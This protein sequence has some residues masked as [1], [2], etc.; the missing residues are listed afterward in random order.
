MYPFI[1]A[2]TNPTVAEILA[3]IKGMLDTESAGTGLW[4]ANHYDAANGWLEI[5][6]KGTPAGTLGSFRALLF[7]GSTPNAAA[8]AYLGTA[9]STTL[10][11]G[12]AQSASTTGPDADYD[13][14]APYNAGKRWTGGSY[15]TP[16]ANIAKSKTPYVSLIES[17]EIC[18]III[19]D[20]SYT[21][22]SIFGAAVEL[23]D[24][25][26]A[27]WVCFN[28][29]TTTGLATYSAWAQT[30]G[31]LGSVNTLST[32][33]YPCGLYHD[34]TN[35]KWVGRTWQGHSTANTYWKNPD[36]FFI[37]QSVTQ[38]IAESGSYMTEFLGVARQLKLGPLQIN[39][40][41]IRDS[42]GVMQGY[43]LCP[44]LGVEGGPLYFDN[45]K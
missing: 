36:G 30:L 14:A 7:G 23:P 31:Y 9:N 32:A 24:G 29:G 16:V 25:N 4:M 19:G 22:A 15:V 35:R 8:L 43:T 44:G 17:D 11:A 5:R 3:A 39:R 6:R 33:S 1:P 38:V 37:P 28:S 34:G 18:A 41:G 26:T 21:H 10:Y 12:I 45:F 20:S 42:L 2:G 13:T 27:A 40:L